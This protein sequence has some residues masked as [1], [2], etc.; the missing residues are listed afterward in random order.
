MSSASSRTKEIVN[1]ALLCAMAYVVMVF[2]RI[3]VISTPFPL[4]FDPKDIV[5]IIGGLIYG[6]IASFMV[7]LVVSFLEM[8]TVSETGWYGFIMNVISTCSFVC[9]AAYIYKKSQSLKGAILGLVCGGLLVV[10]VMLLWNYLIVPIYLRMPRAAVVPFLLPV[11]L[12]FN[13]LKVGIN[14]TVTMLIYKPIVRALRK[15]NLIPQSTSAHSTQ[16]NK[17]P[18]AVWLVSACILAT[19]A[20]FVLALN[21]LV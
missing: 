19:C 20:F 13:L 11:F 9:P 15:A 12:P 3:P 18:V 2:G 1:L 16:G 10:P 6:P 21:G 5:I 14:S 7:S 8:I 4:K 17:K